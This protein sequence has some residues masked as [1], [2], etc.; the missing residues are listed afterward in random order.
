MPSNGTDRATVSRPGSAP[1]RAMYP[2]TILSERS[3]ARCMACAL[4]SRLGTPP[5]KFRMTRGECTASVTSGA[6]SRED[7]PRMR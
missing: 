5:V 6:I 3:I 2:S 7:A 1:S 4:S